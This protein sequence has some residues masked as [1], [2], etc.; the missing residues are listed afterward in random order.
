[1]SK[2]KVVIAGGGIGG[3]ALALTLN[4]IGIECI[5]CESVRNPRPL[6]VGINLQPNAVREM[7]DLG[8]TAADMNEVGVPAKEWALVGLK[9]QEIYSEPHGILA[10]YSW[11]QYA[12]HRGEFHMALYRRF[13]GLAGDDAI[14]WTVLPDATGCR[15]T[16]QNPMR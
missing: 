12:M 13:R 2:D 3:L 8:F 10:G 14:R 15:G 9:G 5:V 11:P 1:M 7:F 6:G 16:E 4:Q